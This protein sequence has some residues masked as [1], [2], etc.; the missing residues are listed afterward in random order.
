MHHLNQPEEW[1]STP[2]TLPNGRARVRL[3]IKYPAILLANSYSDQLA[4]CETTGSQILPGMA[5][6]CEH[7]HFVC[8]RQDQEIETKL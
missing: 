3:H 1:S 7:G 2:H 4:G 8:G 5:E 6:I